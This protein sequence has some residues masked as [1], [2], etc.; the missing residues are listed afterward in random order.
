MKPYIAGSRICALLTLV[1]LRPVL[2]GQW[3][4]LRDSYA[5]GGRGDV[6]SIPGML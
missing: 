2:C 6:A 4:V 3:V 1:V 5:Q